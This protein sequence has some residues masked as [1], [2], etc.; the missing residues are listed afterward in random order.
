MQASLHLEATVTRLHN[1]GS[2]GSDHVGADDLIRRLVHDELH[3]GLLLAPRQRVLHRLE[4]A[5]VDVELAREARRGLFFTEAHGR[6]GRLAEDLRAVKRASPPV[7]ELRLHRESATPCTS[8]QSGAAPVSTPGA[9]DAH[10]C[11]SRG[12]RCGRARDCQ[13]PASQRLQF[14][15]PRGCCRSRAASSRG[16]N[17]RQQ[18][19]CPP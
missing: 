16:R 15:L 2:V 5:D 17:T 3:Q 13:R 18:M 9:C 6:E 12:D 8:K 1:L 10:L 4:P 11:A 7:R 14:A 19:P